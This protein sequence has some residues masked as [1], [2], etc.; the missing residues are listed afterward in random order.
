MNGRY[1]TITE[2]AKLLF[3]IPGKGHSAIN[4]LK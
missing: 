2:E 1:G 3:K 4:V